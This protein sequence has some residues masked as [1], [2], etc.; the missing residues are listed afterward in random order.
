MYVCYVEEAGCTGMLPSTNSSIQPVFAI[1]GL[2]LP[3]S[4]IRTVTRELIALK[5]RFFPNGVPAGGYQHD[6]IG[7]EV[8]GSDIRRMA[9]SAARNDRRFAYSVV[10]EGLGILERNRAL[11]VGRIY[12]KPI[13]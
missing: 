9:R 1:A 13:G 12:V 6:W 10:H 4:Q 8:K 5:Q 11:V 3:R 7:F 2:I